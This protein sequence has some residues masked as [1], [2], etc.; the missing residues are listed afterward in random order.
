MAPHNVSPALWPWIISKPGMRHAHELS[1]REKA[2]RGCDTLTALQHAGWQHH[3]KAL[4]KHWLTS[5]VDPAS[6]PGKQVCVGL[7]HARAF[8]AITIFWIRF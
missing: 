4:C 6:K 1:S 8:E 7:P 3:S 2:L 5:D